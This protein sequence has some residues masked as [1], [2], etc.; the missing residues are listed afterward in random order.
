MHDEVQGIQPEHKDGVVGLVIV[1]LIAFLIGAALI[2]NTRTTAE[3]IDA[4]IQQAAVVS[5]KPAKSTN[6]SGS[7]WEDLKAK[8]LQGTH[9]TL[10][11]HGKNDSFGKQDCT[12]TSSNSIF[13]PSNGDPSDNNQILMTSGNAKGKWAES[14]PSYGVRD[15]CT[16]PFDG[17][18]AELTLPPNPNGKGYYVTTRVLGKPTNN[19]ELSITG[20]LV[21]VKDE[22]GNDLLV[23]GLVTDN[24]FETPTQTIT[25]TKGKVTSVDITGLFEWSGQVCYFEPEN[26][27]YDDAQNY[28]CTDTQLCCLDTDL[29]GT[30]DVC[31]DP[32]VSTDGS[33]SCL[34]GSLTDLACKDYVNEW[35]FNIGDLVGYMWDLDPQGDLK[36]VNIRFYP[37]Q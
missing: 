31:A 14:S 1:G 5:A 23:L 15:T 10:N 11:I 26:Y 32:T 13:I 28:L 34:V 30:Y 2:Y 35:V 27:C 19:P 4:T 22:L 25:R 8:G 6:T 37:V 16:A 33:L 9:Y 7:V 36:L 17:D 3:Y 24:G 29:N 20:E 21:F 18:A 12:A